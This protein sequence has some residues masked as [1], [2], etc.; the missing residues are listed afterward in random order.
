MIHV[1]KRAKQCENGLN[2]NQM[3][4]QAKTSTT[5]LEEQI[6]FE[7]SH[8]FASCHTSLYGPS[9]ASAVP[10]KAEHHMFLTQVC[11]DRQRKRQRASPEE[12]QEHLSA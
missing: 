5:V 4:C 1:V 8:L 11:L 2:L 10:Q 9:I 12:V 3:F 7:C 6:R